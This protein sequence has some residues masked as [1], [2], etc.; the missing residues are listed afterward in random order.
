MGYQQWRRAFSELYIIQ[1]EVRLQPLAR[2]RTIK[3][4]SSIV[5]DDVIRASTWSH[6]SRSLD[7]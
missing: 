7:R 2:L 3:V 6:D 5:E 1:V 4:S